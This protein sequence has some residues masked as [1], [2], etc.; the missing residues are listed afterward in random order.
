[1][2][3]R[4]GGERQGSRGHTQD[5][6]DNFD[7][8]PQRRLPEIRGKRQRQEFSV[9]LGSS[10]SFGETQLACHNVSATNRV[11]TSSLNSNVRSRG[12]RRDQARCA[13][14]Q[15]QVAS[16]LAWSANSRRPA[17]R[18][19]RHLCD[20][21]TSMPAGSPTCATRPKPPFAPRS[22]KVRNVGEI[23]R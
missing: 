13:N 16:L 7:G 5:S 3:D 4:T 18:Q 22:V 20:C 12:I 9:E 11:P 10:V 1:M 14:A 19:T 2:S 8:D 17:T 6:L 23:R 21:S 15:F